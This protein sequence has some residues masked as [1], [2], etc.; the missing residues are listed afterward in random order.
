MNN[1]NI[2][3]MKKTILF[4]MSIVASFCMMN[5][6][7]NDVVIHSNNSNGNNQVVV[8]PPQVTYDDGLN[9]LTVFFGTTSTIDIEYID[10]SGTPYFFVQGEY[11]VDYSTTTYYNLPAGYYTITIHSVYGYTYTGNF[12]VN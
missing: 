11:H 1:E 4:F 10:S 12:T 3:F 9:E 8:V 2:L 6:V 7:A 5:V